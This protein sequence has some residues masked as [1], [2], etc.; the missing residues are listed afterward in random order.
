MSLYS[1]GRRREWEVA[2]LLKGWGLT[3][4]RTAGSKGFCDLIV[5]GPRAVAWVQVKSLTRPDMGPKMLRSIFEK[6][7]SGAPPVVR[8][9]FV[10]IVF[11]RRPARKQVI[12]HVLQLNQGRIVAVRGQFKETLGNALAW[13]LGGAG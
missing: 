7:I 8:P 9:A 10:V 4:L 5:V 6:A 12:T 2:Q 3:V 13:L 11:Q 1:R